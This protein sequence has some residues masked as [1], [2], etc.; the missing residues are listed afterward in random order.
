MPA[1][2]LKKEIT[3]VLMDQG[4]ILNY[5]FAK[6]GAKEL[7]QIAINDG[8]KI[9]FWISNLFFINVVL[10]SVCSKPNIPKEDKSEIYVIKIEN[11][12]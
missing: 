2:N 10:K 11:N 8:Y 1:S 9:F 7:I 12:P 5:K 6:K 4:Y 3:K